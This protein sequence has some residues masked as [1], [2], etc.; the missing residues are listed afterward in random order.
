M[1]WY[2]Y[3]ITQAAAS[4]PVFLAKVGPGLHDMPLHVVVHDELAAVII[5]WRSSTTDGSSPARAR[6]LETDFETD[7]WRHEQIMKESWR[8]C[9]RYLARF[10]TTLTGIDQVHQLLQQHATD[11]AEDLAYVTDRV[12]MGLRILWEPPIATQGSGRGD[13]SAH[14]RP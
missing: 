1:A 8:R 10:G 13:G 7:L 11:F 2:L 3:A 12:E 14:A 6:Q 4:A 9:R 5:E